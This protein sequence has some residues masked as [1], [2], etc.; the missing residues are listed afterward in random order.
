ME[1][2]TRLPFG[3]Y[4][5]GCGP[6]D[7]QLLTSAAHSVLSRADVLISDALIYDSFKDRYGKVIKRP[8]WQDE[9][10]KVILKHISSGKSVARLKVGD[11]T[12]YARTKLEASLAVPTFLIPGISAATSSALYANVLTTSPHADRTIV[13]TG[14]LE[15][16]NMSS[17]L[18][19]YDSET[20]LVL[21]M[22][23]RKITTLCKLAIKN[24]NYP[25]DTPIV[26][27]QRASQKDQRVIFSTLSN[28]SR[29]NDLETPV[30]F[31][32][33][34][35]VS[36]RK[37]N[38]VVWRGQDD[39]RTLPN[40]LFLVGA[41]PGDP[42]LLSLKALN[43]VRRADVVICDSLVWKPMNKLRDDMIVRPKKQSDVNDLIRHY[44]NLGKSVVRL[45][46]G[47]PSM[48]GRVSAEMEAVS[49]SDTVYAVPGISTAMIASLYVF[50]FNVRSSARLT[51]LLT[52][53]C[54]D[55]QIF[56]QQYVTLQIV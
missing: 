14:T 52:Y 25:A 23:L 7:P 36:K 9:L 12:L 31:V 42:S 55:T 18:P 10:N 30:T 50:V 43:L 24:L 37:T 41:G 38:L 3:L 33:G 51:Y 39:D 32:V 48:Y 6:G 40:S 49:T 11:V 35:T 1:T 47:D 29:F 19:K 4:L 13:V 17:D 22:A 56:L 8:R 34:R 26:A 20:T 15:K 54:T 44:L 53:T 2:T 27:I 16:E 28:P 45:K 46:T 5:V 21:L